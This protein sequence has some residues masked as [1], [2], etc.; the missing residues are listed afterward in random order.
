MTQMIL[1]IYDL[2]MIIVILYLNLL[3][4]KSKENICSYVCYIF[5]SRKKTVVNKIHQILNHDKSLFPNPFDY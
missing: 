4:E 3:N 5:N 2:T 1:S